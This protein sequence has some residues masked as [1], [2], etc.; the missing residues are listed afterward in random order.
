MTRRYLNN[1]M[2]VALCWAGV[3]AV[4][5]TACGGTSK[6]AVTPG[7]AGK[8]ENVQR[9]LE[10]VTA[11]GAPGA[12]ALVR[13]GDQTFRLTSGYGNLE[14]KASMRQ[15]DRFRI[16]SVTKTFVATVVLQLGAAFASPSRAPRPVI[17]EWG[18]RFDDLGTPPAGHVVGRGQARCRRTLGIRGLE[19]RLCDWGIRPTRH[20][21]GQKLLHLG[22]IA[23]LGGHGVVN[24]SAERCQREAT[25]R[26]TQQLAAL[27]IQCFAGQAER[28]PAVEF[29]R[30][31]EVGGEKALRQARTDVRDEEEEHARVLVERGEPCSLVLASGAKRADEEPS[32]R[33]PAL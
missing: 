20:T 4:T 18:V 17:L 1:L 16:G 29:E 30:A 22:P 3:I 11:A 8:E 24:Q 10:R 23:F 2:A 25:P 21:R 26:G 12:I 7:P 31:R 32:P 15:T 14:Q 28:V 9:A 27:R 5:A 13:D 19:G 6:L 33:P